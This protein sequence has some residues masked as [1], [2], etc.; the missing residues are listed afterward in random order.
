MLESRAMDDLGLLS[1]SELARRIRERRL[2][3]REAVEHHI[4]AIERVNPRLNAVVATRFAEARAEA[5]AA[6]AQVSRAQRES[7]PPFHGV[8]CTI[9]ESFAMRGM[10][11]TAGM[12]PRRGRV[13]EAD[14]IAVTRMRSAGAIPCLLY[15][16]DAADE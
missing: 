4:A 15:T 14:A 5:D 10:P 2:T 16:S 7:L 3:S 12:V 6:D 11:H 8:P 9:K 1:A 13:A